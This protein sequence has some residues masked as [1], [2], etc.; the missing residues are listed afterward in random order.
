MVRG[1]IRI[2]ALASAASICA[3]WPLAASA[4]DDGTPEVERDD[5]E[6][7]VIGQRPDIFLGILPE[8][9][10]DENDIAAYGFNTIG[11]L[12]QEV[13]RE[14]DPTGEGPVVLINGQLTNGIGDIADL[15]TEA[16]SQIQV[17]PA[18]VSARLGQSPS[19][20][21]INVVVRPDL[22]Q[23]T[24]NAEAGLATRGDA[25]RGEGEINL[26]KLDNGNRRSLV[27]KVQRTDGLLESD[28]GI[29]PDPTAVPFDQTGNIFGRTGF[30]TEIDPAL[31]AL[32]GRPVTAAGV[33]AGTA[34]PTL[35]QFAA[36]ADRVNNAR[37]SAYRSLIDS[38]E[39]YSLNGNVTE[40]LNANTTLSS[41]ARIERTYSNGLHGLTAASLVVP[42]TSPFS[43]FSRDVS[44]A[45]L[46]GQP[47][48]QRQ[49]G[50]SVTLG[51]TLNT[52]VGGFNVSA[53]ASFAHRVLRSETD[54][55]YDLTALQGGIAAGTVNPFAGPGAGQ[56]GAVRTD[57]S[58]SR[59]DVFDAQ[60]VAAGPL[61]RLPTG[62]V[63][64]STRVGMRIDR[65][66]TFTRGAT[67]NQTREFSR[68]ELSA[69]AN[70]QIPILPLEGIDL[71]AV[72]LDLTAGI[73]DVTTAGTLETYGAAVNWSA[74]S[75]ASLRFELTDEQVPTAGALLTDPVVV[76]ANYR[77]FDFV[78]RETVLVDYVTGG[79]PA[80][81]AQRRRVTKISGTANPL[82]SG[83]LTLNAEYTRVVGRNAVAALP[84]ASAAVQLAFP[85]RYIR[86]PGGVLVRL[87]ARPV[88]FE[89][90]TVEYR[91]WG[92]NFQHSY[93]A[94]APIADSGQAAPSLGR[95]WRLDVR[96]DHTWYLTSERLARQG[97]PV[98][99]LLSGGAAGYG[100]GQ[101]RHQV[102]FSTAVFHRGI[103]MQLFADWNGRSVINA[104]TL[105]AP[106][107]IEFAPRL[108]VSARTF[109]NLGPLFPNAGWLKGARATLEVV[110]LLDSKQRV[111]DELG[112][113]PIRYQPFL[114]DPVGRSIKL[115][116][117]KAF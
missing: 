30:G 96:A 67:V 2:A 116:L 101:Q 10:L 117:R 102:Q 53:N 85:D 44:L 92:F 83:D 63:S 100:G 11:D 16:A 40:R 72:T 98:I 42:E 108:Q 35:A 31:S 23:I 38:L 114:L 91:H 15:P 70:L 18:T 17:L 59:S 39:S 99:D 104:G 76:N 62:P 3:V 43:P 8:N 107:E 27:F 73:R 26:L 89:R 77:V 22:A 24:V 69:Q 64:L 50:T 113:T 25:W 5:R 97:L 7:I 32:V 46:L 47:L 12:V 103:G 45:L 52:R 84:P 36:N 65:F 14:L 105:A 90:D 112:A 1:L 68:D 80:L 78:R 4:Q 86:S 57:L 58:R 28:R 111:T 51:N 49:V 41:T 82:P 74:S 37:D 88:G 6:L 110:N 109:A 79:N 93:G 34:N 20:R 87:D 55:D 81:L 56:L 13:S 66:Y 95:G 19:R 94:V 54:P 61:F 75:A 71:G 60:V 29:L 9:E 48:R 33:P 115:S 21:V 106:S